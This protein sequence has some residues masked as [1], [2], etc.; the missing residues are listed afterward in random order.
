MKALKQTMKVENNKVL[1]TLPEDFN[2]QEVEVIVLS[3]E[4]DFVLTEEQKKI[5]DERLNEPEENY[6]SMKQ[7]LDDLKKKYGV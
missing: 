4:E 5:L 2:D 7:C 6:I 1:I 3:K